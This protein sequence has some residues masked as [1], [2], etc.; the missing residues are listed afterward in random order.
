MRVLAYVHG[1]VPHLQAG[2]ETMLHALMRAL[3]DAGHDIAVVC[4]KR[5]AARTDWVI[6]GV[7]SRARPG[8]A[9]ADAY[10]RRWRPDVIVSHHENARHAVALA[11]RL[12]AASVAL[13]HNDFPQ[14]H[15]FL[16][17]DR[18]DLAVCNTQ[19]LAARL[20]PER[21]GIASVVVRPPVDPTAHATTPGDL[22]TMVNLYRMKGPNTMWRLA[23]RL[24]QTRFLAVRGGYGQQDVRAG[25]ANVEVIDTTTD[26]RSDVWSRTRVLIVPSQYESYGMAAVEALASGIPVIAAPTPGLR[27]ALGRGAVFVP[28]G[29]PLSWERH[30]TT[31]MR[32]RHAWERASTLARERSAQIAHQTA[33]DLE[34]WVAAVAALG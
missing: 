28:R 25:Y 20:R 9:A 10:A 8:Q 23:H 1:A 7:P 31:L 16:A 33:S 11:R 13:M 30:L 26:M 34:A 6:D 4:T 24:P 15:R 21:R 17:T 2:S 32:D 18:P 27:E 14:A 22:V 19:W 3:R 5:P 12:Q 29:D